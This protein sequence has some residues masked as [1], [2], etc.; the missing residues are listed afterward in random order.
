MVSEEAPKR[1]QDWNLGMKLIFIFRDPI[2]RAYSH[3]CMLLR[4]GGATDDIEAEMTKDRRLIQEGLYFK[5]LNRF[6]E[7]FLEDQIRCLVFDDLKEDP[8]GFLR[9]VYSFLGVEEVDDE[10][11]INRKYHSR[12]ARPRSDVM[13]QVATSLLW[14]AKHAGRWGARA[15]HYLRKSRVAEIYNWLNGGDEFPPLPEHKRKELRA[16]YADDVEHLSEHL[17]RDLAS[18]WL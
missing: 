13:H 18:E 6:G 5:H 1:M 9:Q 11:M 12:K 8:E 15:V 14:G 16:F 4:A 3:Y 17:N 2:D 10:E 7:Y